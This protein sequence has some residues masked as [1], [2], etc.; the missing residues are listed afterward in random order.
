MDARKLSKKSSIAI[1]IAVSLAIPLTGGLVLA[2]RGKGRLDEADTSSPARN[3]D[4][5][6]ILGVGDRLKITFFE[7]MDVSNDASQKQGANASGALHT[8]FQRMDLTGEYVIDEEGMISLPR[9]GRFRVDV[10]GLQ[11][12]QSNLTIA[13]EKSMGRQVD[14]NVAIIDRAPVYVVGPVKN[15]GSYK[16]VPGMTVLHAVALAGGLDHRMGTTS[17]LIE[18]AREMERLRKASDD[19]KRLVARRA[20]LE[21]ERNGVALAKPSEQLVSLAG[22]RGAETLLATE[23]ANMHIEKTK[24]ERQETEIGASV[25]AARKELE[26][27]KRKLSQLNVQQDI[28]TERLNNLQSLMSKG[29]TTRNGVIIVRSELSDIE[30]KREDYRLAVVQG[31]ARLMQAE[32]LMRHM[33]DD[34][35]AN[36]AQAIA[37]TDVEIAEARQTLAST[38][39]VATIMDESNTRIMNTRASMAPAYEI[40]H[41]G[42][43]GPTVEAA[44]ETSPLK[45]GD[46]LKI[47]F[48]LSVPQGGDSDFRQKISFPASK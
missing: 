32:L 22:E 33:S 39:M 10:G 37:A 24:R 30:A 13:F 27:L 44:Q 34:L 4:T 26:A 23:I 3:A 21:A 9:L 42:R 40:V 31:E 45:P 1:L 16:H 11:D 28:R 36:L 19:L 35:A 25:Q 46:V 20:R 38:E 47:S 6:A 7:M 41:Q 17:E 48:K 43:N 5:K 12:L 29:L 18:G 14:I 8:F 15:P 2:E